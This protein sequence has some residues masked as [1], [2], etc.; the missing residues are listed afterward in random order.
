MWRMRSLH[1]GKLPSQPSPSKSSGGRE[2]RHI[3]EFGSRREREHTPLPTPAGGMFLWSFNSMRD[4]ITLAQMAGAPLSCP[5]SLYKDP[6]SGRLFLLLSPGEL[7]DED[8]RRLFSLLSEYATAET[9]IPADASQLA[10]HYSTVIARNALASL[11][12][13]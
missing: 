8:D 6:E 4:V 11:A 1:Q 5:S 2:N 13:L 12:G 3:P 10:S 9:D 7:S